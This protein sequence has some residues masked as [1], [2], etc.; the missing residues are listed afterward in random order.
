MYVVWEVLG[1]NCMYVF[2]FII[3]LFV[4][5][6]IVFLNNWI[7]EGWVKKEENVNY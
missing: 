5:Y 7:C 6:C 4:M 2:L 1:L 3:V